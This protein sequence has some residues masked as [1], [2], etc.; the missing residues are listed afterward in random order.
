MG[1]PIIFVLYL[2]MSAQSDTTDKSKTAKETKTKKQEGD[3][4]LFL[5]ILKGLGVVVGAATT[6][7]AAVTI[8]SVIDSKLDYDKRFNET[9][10]PSIF[11]K[12][13]VNKQPTDQ[14]S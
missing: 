2:A 8:P 5:D 3:S 4:S 12:S 7:A 6:G 1:Q 10:K 14:S 13:D 11:S 9:L